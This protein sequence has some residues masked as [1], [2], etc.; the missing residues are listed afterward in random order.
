MA[1]IFIGMYNFVEE[2][3]IFNNLSSIRRDLKKTS[4]ENNIFQHS[5]ANA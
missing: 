5:S 2:P 3:D 4:Q 1:Q